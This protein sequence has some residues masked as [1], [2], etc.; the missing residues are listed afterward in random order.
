MTAPLTF[1]SADELDL[2]A[3][4]MCDA[5]MVQALG[6]GETLLATYLF[7][8]SAWHAAQI[9]ERRSARIWKVLDDFGRSEDQ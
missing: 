3:I 5:A 4:A 1:P 8:A 6:A 9:G 7:E 2:D